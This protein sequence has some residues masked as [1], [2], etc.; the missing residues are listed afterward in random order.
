MNH[1][2][3][4]RVEPAQVR[5]RGRLFVH[6]F[7][8][9]DRHGAVFLG[10]ISVGY[11]LHVGGGDGLDFRPGVVDFAP[12]AVAIVE[13]QLEQD[14]RIRGQLAVL[15]GREIV[16]DLLQFF[17]R[18]FLPFELFQLRVDALLDL[19]RGAAF[20]GLAA[21]IEQTGPFARL[22]LGVNL[23]GHLRAEHQTFVQSPGAGGE[24]LRQHLEP[25]GVFV[26][27]R[28]RV[29][30]NVHLRIGLGLGVHALLRK[31]F[32]LERGDLRRVGFATRDAGK[33]FFSERLGFSRVEVAHQKQRD[34]LR[35]VVN[36]VEL[37]RLRLGNGR[38]V[39]GPADRGPLVRMRFPEHGLERLLKLAQRS[40]F[41]PH[42]ALLEHDIALRVKFAKDRA[43]Q[44]LRFHPAPQLQFV[45]RHRDEVGGQVLGRERVHAGAAR[46][47]VDPVEFVFHQDLPLFCHQ[48]VELFLQLP[49]SLRLVFRLLQVVY[50]PAPPGG[51]HLR[52]LLAH[53]LANPFLFGDDF[54]VLLVVL[55][56]DRRRAFEHHVLEQVRHA[57]DTGP[58]VGAADVRH[59]AARDGRFI[60]PL[61]HQQLH[62]IGKLLLDDRDLLSLD[63]RAQEQAQQTDRDAVEGAYAKSCAQG[64]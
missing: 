60:V 34:V 5:I 24:D 10:E 21:R 18:N 17:R 12:V 58:F 36:A 25:V 43:Q 8:R 32:D 15:E 48:F 11:A 40:G 35:G 41:R 29:P 37:V 26:L 2:L 39:R 50:L 3:L 59:P 63:R 6:R 51:A 62:P 47:G 46:G 38:N 9:V 14:R 7:P 20:L 16:F 54:E 42:A 55:G 31:L 22:L 1:R 23:G 53:P 56:A 30:E 13:N 57:G 52:H 49:V 28:H 19:L 45:G 33:I 44:T 4:L 61:H 27:E 64:C